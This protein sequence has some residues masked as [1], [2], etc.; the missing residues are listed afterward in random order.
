MTT[1]KLKMTTKSSSEQKAR[2]AKARAAKSSCGQKL[3]RL[4]KLTTPN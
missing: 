1:K 4:A 2:A 3:E